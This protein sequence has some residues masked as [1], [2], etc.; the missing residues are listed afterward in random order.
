MV[1]L[2]DL[3]TYS[4]RSGPQPI[5]RAYGRIMVPFGYTDRYAEFKTMEDELGIVRDGELLKLCSPAFLCFSTRL[6]PSSDS[7]IW[8]R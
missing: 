1:G 4:S 6:I 3:A 8:T 2:T 7:Y 5:E